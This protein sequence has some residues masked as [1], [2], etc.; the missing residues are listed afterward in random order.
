MLPSWPTKS[1]CRSSCPCLLNQIHPCR[2][3][4]VSRYPVRCGGAV[5]GPDRIGTIAGLVLVDVH[6]CATDQ[7]V[8]AFTTNQDVQIAPAVSV[9]L[10]RPPFSV[11]LA[12]SPVMVSSR[13]D[14]VTFRCPTGCRCC[15]RCRCCRSRSRKVH[16]NTR[17]AALLGVV[18]GIDVLSA[19]QRVKAGTAEQDVSSPPC[20]K[21]DRRRRLP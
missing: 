16:I 14:P 15:R 4:R 2:C 3:R 13:A 1:I 9:S 17:A 6:P 19:V 18:G 21:A 11:F 7:K 12:S 5:T 10:P 8:V 20:P